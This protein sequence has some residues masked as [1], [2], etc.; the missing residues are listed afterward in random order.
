MAKDR[1]TDQTIEADFSDGDILYG[2]DINKII[3]VFKEG[4]NKNKT[5]LNRMLTGS[6]YFFIADDL[7]GL[8]A[9]IS[10]RTPLD[11][12]RGYVFNNKEAEG[13]LEVYLY[14]ES[15]GVWEL[16]R[17]IL[18]LDMLEDK[19]VDKVEGKDLSTNDYTTTEK[20]KLAGIASGAEV[21]VQSD[22]NVTNIISDAFIK[23][24]P[25]KVS[26]FTNDSGFITTETDP[27]FTAWDKSTGISIT[28]SQVSD[29][30]EATQALSGLMSATDKQRLDALHALLEE[31]TE[32]NVVDSINEILAIF[33]NYPEGADL[34]TALAG[35]VDKTS[36]VD[37][38]TTNDAT[39]VLS[40]KQ[41]KALED[42]KEALTNKAIDFSVVDDM[43]YPT[44][45]A[46]KTY[47]DNAISSL[48]G[49]SY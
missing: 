3:S 32:N 46:V 29:L 15:E 44:T 35:K 43:K 45:K 11:G 47:V 21:N 19:K 17:S 40:A 39:K 24:K 27:I 18:G 30:I 16:S 7:S 48:L 41:G 31:D 8:T 20:N 36:I 34:V 38:L 1:I 23:N 37:N 6:E 42:N 10:E 9:L 5:D 22:W 25:T 13:S 4:I 33:N 49:G 26:D 28:K 14:N 12:Q 2:S